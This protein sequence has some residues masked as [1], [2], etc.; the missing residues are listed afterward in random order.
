MADL[1]LFPGPQ[2]SSSRCGPRLAIAA[3]QPGQGDGQLNASGQMPASFARCHLSSC[4]SQTELIQIRGPRGPLGQP[5]RSHYILA[6]PYNDRVLIMNPGLS[7]LQAPNTWKMLRT[8]QRPQIT[9]FV[10]AEVAVR[11]GPR[12]QHGVWLLSAHLDTPRLVRLAHLLGVWLLT[13][14]PS[15][16]R[17]SR[18]FRWARQREFLLEGKAESGAWSARRWLVSGE[19]FSG[20][21]WGCGLSLQGH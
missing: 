12:R 1:G 8:A 9:Q 18:H 11:L 21:A 13:P 5:R 4:A 10:P 2:F 19:W 20:P 15:F 6:L 17:P 7:D 14:G 16:A 3:N